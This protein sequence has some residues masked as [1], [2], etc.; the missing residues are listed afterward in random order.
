MLRELW[1]KTTSQAQNEIEKQH[2]KKVILALNFIKTPVPEWHQEVINSQ[3]P[4]IASALSQQEVVKVFQFYDQLR[5][6]E[7][8]RNE[9]ILASEVQRTEFIAATKKD[10]S[11]N[12][13][14]YVAMS[15]RPPTPFNEKAT[16]VWNECESLVAQLFT[17][18]NPL[19]PQ[20]LNS[21]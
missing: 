7:A 14:K 19:K 17:K 13:S 2:K 3:F 18:G 5:R 4:L 8:I 16:A 15:Y 20:R 11:H 1:S 9:L 21:H 12:F 10:S 6:L